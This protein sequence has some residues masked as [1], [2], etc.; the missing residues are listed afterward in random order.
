M[1]ILDLPV[2]TLSKPLHAVIGVVERKQT[3][4]ILSNVMV[5]IKD[6]QLSITGTDTEVEIIGKTNMIGEGVVLEGI[7][8]PGRKLADICRALPENAAIELYQDQH[9]ITLHS[10][11]SRFTLAS[12]PAEQFP[13]IDIQPGYLSFTIP[14][15]QLKTLFQR[16]YFAMAQQDVR[17]YLNGLLLEMNDHLLTAVA[18]DGHRLALNSTP[19]HCPETKK[20]TV[21]VPRKGVIE[22]LRLLDDTETEIGVTLSQ[23]HIHI[24]ST[25]FSFTS[26]LVEGQF[27]D[28]TRVIPRNGNKTILTDKDQ[29]KDALQRSA[30]LSNEKYKGVR[31]E[32]SHNLL[33]ISS[34]NPEQES[35]EEEIVIDYE[36]EAIDI[37]FNVSYIIDILNTKAA[38]NVKITMLD[39]KS[40]A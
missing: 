8:L 14:Q 28:Y 37:G 5:S 39:T 11:R 13:N 17:Y 15:N 3:L 25:D 34:N 29:L 35:A 31:F 26:K 36:G 23:G 18:T 1:K 16:T 40:S 33:K 32:L 9:K 30:I 22:L 4:P 2:E 20:T 27:P 21:I 38:C 12:L 7:T 19:I 24:N 10:G 6:N